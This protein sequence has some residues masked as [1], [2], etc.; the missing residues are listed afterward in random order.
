MIALWHYDPATNRLLPHCS[1]DLRAVSGIQDFAAT[2]PL[3][4]IYVCSSD[5]QTGLSLEQQ[6]RVASVDT[7]FIGRNVYLYCASEGLAIVFRTSFDHSPLVR[8]LR[9]GQAQFLT[10]VRTVGYPKA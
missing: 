7:G 6:Y 5:H 3:E 1:G 4:M 8:A 10:F 2:A 9:L